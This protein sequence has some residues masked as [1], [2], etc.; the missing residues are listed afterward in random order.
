[1]RYVF[2]TMSAATVATMIGVTCLA[3]DKAIPWS[4]FWP[5]ASGWFFGDGIGLVGVAPFLLI[6]IFPWVRKQITPELAED[7]PETAPSREPKTLADLGVIGEAIG[8]SAAILIALWFMLGPRLGSR[9]MLYLG[10]VPI[11]WVATRR[12]PWRMAT[13]MI[14]TKPR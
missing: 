8:Q 1:M 9:E 4:E 11:I 5:S 13:Q 7:Q 10:F 3:A 6:H 12:I 14:G 2:V